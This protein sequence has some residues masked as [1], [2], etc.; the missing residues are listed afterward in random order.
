M[1]FIQ[2]LIPAVFIGLSV[3]SCGKGKIFGIKGKGS[4]VTQTRNVSGFNE[5]HLS[6]DADVYYVQDSF[7]SV[8]ISAQPNVLSELE[9]DVEGN[10]LEIEFD[11]RV[12]SHSKITI[13][14]HAPNIQELNIS[15]SGK[16]EAQGAI[17]ASNMKLKI[18]GSGDLILSSLTGSYLDA[19]IS[20]S[21]NITV[22]GGTLDNEDLKISG[23]G[24]INVVN[25]VAKNATA[26]ISG[27]G[28]ISVQATEH[29]DASIS[30]SGDIKYLGN[31]LINVNIS[32]SGKV[33][34]L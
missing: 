3:S 12:F 24:D 32:G 2:F 33:I 8:E 23:S 30:G 10:E 15:G 26:N 6:I 34:H 1:K 18:S 11:K 28:N 31:P 27:S 5:I 19:N 21:G 7:Y 29:L 17:N 20:G 25:L 13:T 16:I 9:T 4:N 22:S 14:I